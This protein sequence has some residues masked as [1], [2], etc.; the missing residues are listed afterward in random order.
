MFWDD[1][2][3]EKPL[4]Q[5]SLYSKCTQRFENSTYPNET[6]NFYGGSYRND[7][8]LKDNEKVW[9]G[10]SYKKTKEYEAIEGQYK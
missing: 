8:G 9:Y 10:Q 5:S 6:T 4:E 7:L 3:S 2:F 1:T